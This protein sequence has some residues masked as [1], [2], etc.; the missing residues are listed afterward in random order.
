MAVAR[1]FLSA[2]HEVFVYELSTKIERVRQDAPGVTWIQGSILDLYCLN[3]SLSGM[4]ICIHLAAFL[5]VERTEQEPLKC[6]YINYEGT[7]N[8]LEACRNGNVPK[9]VFASSSEVYGEPLE[10]PISELTPTQG[11]TVYAISKLAGEELVKAYSKG[12]AFGFTILRFF[13]TYGPFQVRQ[14]LISK[15]IYAAL[16]GEQIV[17]NGDGT[18]LRSY[19]YS[20]DTARGVYLASTMPAADGR[21]FNI[22]NDKERVTINALL[23]IISE[24]IGKESM[25]T[26]A[27]DRSFT[28]GD[29]V[30]T[31]EINFR[32][33]DVDLARRLLGYDPQV[34]LREG[35]EM[36]LRS[37]K[38]LDSW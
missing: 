28:A 10:N 18:Q 20:S 3:E 30:S 5:G 25:F 19:C 31:R 27:H 6:M 37:N 13:N 12:G 1:E 4:D 14:F 9:V 32:V 24:I 33:C 8:V 34:S 23:G 16:R 17:I 22:G 36:F 11:R 21:V 26:Y 35:L 15:M 7:K 29:R 38:V 2:G